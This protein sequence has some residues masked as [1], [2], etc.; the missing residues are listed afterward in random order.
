MVPTSQL[1]PGD[2][3]FYAADPNDPAS[4]HHVAVA[5]GG[6]RMVEAYAP[7]VPIR[8]VAIRRAGFFAAARPST[9]PSSGG[10][11]L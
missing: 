8:V 7:G 6:G 1:Q 10:H 2:L 4:I 9:A 11:D 3:L 5:I